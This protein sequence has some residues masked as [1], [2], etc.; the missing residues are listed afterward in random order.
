MTTSYDESANDEIDTLRRESSRRVKKLVDQL[1]EKQNELASLQVDKQNAERELNKVRSE[2][3]RELNN[4]EHQLERTKRQFDLTEQQLHSKEGELRQVQTDL[5][6]HETAFLEKERALEKAVASHTA[7]VRHLE[8]QIADKT[9][10]LTARDGRISELVKEISNIRKQHSAVVS[11]AQQQGAASVREQEG[12]AARLRANIEDSKADYDR[13]NKQLTAAMAERSSL[14]N[15]VAELQ[16]RLTLL[17]ATHR[18]KMSQLNA[19]LVDEQA[20]TKIATDR[21]DQY[22]I[23]MRRL[24]EEMDS[25]RER[26]ISNTMGLEDANESLEKELRATRGLMENTTKTYE[27]EIDQ[28][29]GALADRE[30]ELAKVHD[31]ARQQAVGYEERIAEDQALHSETVE[32]L[33]M[34]AE[35]AA[36]QLYDRDQDVLRLSQEL[37][38]AREASTIKERDVARLQAEIDDVTRDT[39]ARGDEARAERD[40]L[41]ERVAALEYELD[42]AT[43]GLRAAEDVKETVESAH[44]R[45]QSELDAAT[46]AIAR[47]KTKM[48]AQAETA[49]IHLEDAT[50]QHKL[51]ADALRRRV[52]QLGA[53]LADTEGREMALT[54]QLDLL[55]TQRNELQDQ[56]AD[57]EGRAGQAEAERDDLTHRLQQEG[58]SW[59]RRLEAADKTHAAEMA[60]VETALAKTRVTLTAVEEAQTRAAGRVEE[61][62]AE[63]ASVSDAALVREN[64]LEDTT[65][66]LTGELQAAREEAERAV[67]A[68]NQASRQHDIA[69][70]QLRSDVNRLEARLDDERAE[71]TRQ[72]EERSVTIEGLTKELAA[73][74]R[75]GRDAVTRSD[76]LAGEVTALRELNGKNVADHRE[77]VRK[78]EAERAKNTKDLEEAWGL[79]R[80]E[81][82]ETETLRGQ[83]AEETDGLRDT[84]RRL[85]EDA[86]Q[87]ALQ[88]QDT[89]AERADDM[90]RVEQEHAATR[91]ELE[92]MTRRKEAVEAELADAQDRLARVTDSARDRETELETDGDRLRAEI[93]E[94]NAVLEGAVAEHRAEADGAA[95]TIADLQAE[96]QDTRDA[97]LSAE[98][99]VRNLKEDKAGLE[100][101]SADLEELQTRHD[102]VLRGKMDQEQA[103]ADLTAR[104]DDARREAA[105]QVG[106]LEGEVDAL[107]RRVESEKLNTEGA[108]TSAES[109][110]REMSRKLQ[111]ERAARR[112]DT[113][114]FQQELRMLQSTVATEKRAMESQITALKTQGDSRRAR[115][116]ET[117]L[118]SSRRLHAAQSTRIGSLESR[119]ATQRQYATRLK[120]IMERQGLGHLIPTEAKASE[121]PARSR[122][123]FSGGQTK[124]PYMS[125][126]EL[127]GSPSRRE[128]MRP[129][130]TPRI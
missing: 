38:D 99:A 100:R 45:L 96:V 102:A 48:K 42:H 121:T 40:G 18:D 85:E 26:S 19:D 110:S 59:A 31:E 13:V 29:R 65:I 80:A 78:L 87:T 50:E 7:K 36:A 46:K 28:L 51:E 66:Q 82:A 124:G 86:H 22:E 17:E 21:A 117:E 73:A 15:E 55:T 92:G 3:G 35:D 33:R 70:Q 97:L 74:K 129:D 23:E 68:L 111:E 24:R 14:Q 98:G 76:K 63:L 79:Y 9:A 61:L 2:S 57:T 11:R 126:R 60:D 101:V 106:A 95:R 41:S 113:L 72:A 93:D 77:V 122:V 108:V 130:R 69:A 67:E 119:L 83:L 44:T 54:N 107:K 105:I 115:S 52:E 125:P 53:D 30:A 4:L 34:D 12:I 64:G 25:Q 43:N 16:T 84:V 47:L 88:A 39:K 8:E 116:A 91:E 56:L 94:L 123:S 128:A 109:D 27:A 6:H 62:E 114:K 89:E 81:Q 103:L 104:L 37:D 71:Y 90:R 120:H 5:K 49:A 1:G 10:D 20:K 127:T 32:A 75:D 58:A 118:E 112:Q